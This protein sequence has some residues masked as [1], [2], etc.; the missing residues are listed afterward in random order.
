MKE[1]DEVSVCVCVRARAR[2]QCMRVF[3]KDD[4]QEFFVCWNAFR[5][6]SD[7]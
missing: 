5:N 4:K 1:R 2:N 7:I 3:Q 6:A